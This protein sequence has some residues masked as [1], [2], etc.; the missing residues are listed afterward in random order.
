VELGYRHASESLERHADEL[1][2]RIAVA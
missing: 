2:R 1:R